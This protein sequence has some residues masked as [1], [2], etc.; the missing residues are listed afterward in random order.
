MN[1]KLFT[2]ILL[3]FAFATFSIAQTIQF[4]YDAAGNCILKY[5]TVVLLRS[6]DIEE[7]T[8]IPEEEEEGKGENDKWDS[9]R[10]DDYSLTDDFF[11]G[12]QT[13][14][15]PNPTKGILQIQFLHK[16]AELPVNYALTQMNG[17]RITE[18]ATA[19]HLMT[20]DL[21]GYASG[22]Y[23]LRLTIHGKSE[24]YKIIKQ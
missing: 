9:S 1:T 20:L 19:N 7:E 15:F 11:E 5:K 18:G 14:I 23:F 24:T 16:A 10:Q 8:E 2:T 13:I 21:S 22:I 12:I 4:E 17:R 3:V 6:A